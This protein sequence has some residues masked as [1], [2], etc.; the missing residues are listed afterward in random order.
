MSESVGA[1]LLTHTAKIVSAFARNHTVSNDALPGVIAGV[2]QAMAQ[3]GE[4]PA[5]DT[6]AKPMVKVSK[7]VFPSHIV[8][9]CCGKEL[10]MLKRHLQTVHGLEPHQYRTKYGLPGSYPMV[11]PNY[12]E[13]RSHLAKQL[14]LGT[15]KV[16]PSKRR[17]F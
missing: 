14:G 10:S 8:C 16:T 3:L 17:R 9:L 15:S 11:A 5:T 12:S 4:E 1:G 2:Y 13:T 6:P 7:S